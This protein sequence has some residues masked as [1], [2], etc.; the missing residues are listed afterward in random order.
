MSTDYFNQLQVYKSVQGYTINAV[1][2][3]I[4]ELQDAIENENN[5]YIKTA[6][7]ERKRVLETTLEKIES[8]E[9]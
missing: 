3:A 2:K 9:D 1:A 7:I 5:I 6:Y 4:K 8:F